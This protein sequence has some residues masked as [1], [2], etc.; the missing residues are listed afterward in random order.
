MG[1]ETEMKG[2]WEKIFDD[3][4]FAD[5]KVPSPEEKKKIYDKCYRKIRRQIKKEGL[6]LTK[7]EM[8]EE[9]EDCL[10]DQL[11]A[12]QLETEKARKYVGTDFSTETR[13]RQRENRE[14]AEDIRILNRVNR[15]FYST[16]EDREEE[17]N[18]ENK[19][20]KRWIEEKVR[21][22]SEG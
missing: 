2:L 14:L 20:L 9:I 18:K 1:E 12:F 16:G 3:V 8:N 11:Y 4:L 5:G 19:R 15:D 13:S 10:R 7:E 6:T 22:E 17:R 21:S